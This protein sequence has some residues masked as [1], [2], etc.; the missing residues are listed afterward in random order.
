TLE[1]EIITTLL[2]GACHYPYRQIRE[3]VGA[4]KATERDELLLLGTRDRGRHDEL[5]RAFSS[6]YAFRFDI[7]M[8]IGGFRDMHRH[9]R[10]VQTMQ[11]F[12]NA[13]GFDVP[14]L[15]GNTP[16]HATCTQAARQAHAVY[17][18]LA[19]SN[20]S[21][22]A[23]TAQYVLPLGTRCRSLFKMDFS[24]A[25]YISELRSAPQGH[26]SYRRV[27]WEMHQAIAKKHPM[28]AQFI[29]VTDINTPVDP[30]QR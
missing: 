3:R 17:D 8:D 5:L 24:E 13:H 2:Y 15:L 14:E 28:L 4:M 22:A 27:A 21:D 29:R 26:V 23:A 7:L 16:L 20:L 18:Q 25:S 10:C 12:T 30:L 9:R 19:L 6:G 11:S 1:M